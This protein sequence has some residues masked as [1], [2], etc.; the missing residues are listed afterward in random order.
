[1]FL[2]PG[3]VAKIK[4]IDE[5]CSEIRDDVSS[6]N[7]LKNSDNDIYNNKLKKLYVI[8][9]DYEKT[10][11]DEIDVEDV[12][13]ALMDPNFTNILVNGFSITAPSMLMERVVKSK[14]P[15]TFDE[16][17]EIVI[18]SR[19]LSYDIAQY[20]H[21]QD[22]NDDEKIFKKYYQYDKQIYDEN[23][24][25]KE[26]ISSCIFLLIYTILMI[27]SFDIDKYTKYK[28]ITNYGELQYYNISPSMFLT[29]IFIHKSRKS[30]LFN[31]IHFSCVFMT[32]QYYFK[33]E[34]KYII[35]VITSS[36]AYGAIIHLFEET[37]LYGSI[38]CIIALVSLL[39]VNIIFGKKKN[40]TSIIPIILCIIYI[41]PI[42]FY[43]SASSVGG[44]MGGFCSSIFIVLK[45]NII[46]IPCNIN[47]CHV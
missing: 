11:F 25:Y 10:G 4:Y 28:Y 18:K 35:V 19:R 29:Y 3:V 20:K 37:N 7:H 22:F 14:K 12:K 36:V 21:L 23:I 42:L 9:K 8:F 43:P 39:F 13:K 6:K 38:N 47:V 46:N 41:L 2:S 24:N 40:E 27:L 15:L 34:I 32:L 17:S 33:T 45:K 26:I 30:L 1:M 5:D 16:F 31:L 44:L